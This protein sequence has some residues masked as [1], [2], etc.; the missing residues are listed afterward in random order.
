MKVQPFTMTFYSL[1]FSFQDLLSLQ[2]FSVAS[3][4]QKLYKADI[5]SKLVKNKQPN[6]VIY[7]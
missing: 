4:I 7:K 1:S 5:L 3:E 6:V 2:L